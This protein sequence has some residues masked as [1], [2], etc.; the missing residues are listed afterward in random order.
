MT[1]ILQKTEHP[2]AAGPSSDPDA[3]RWWALPVLM[4]G[5][6]MIVLDFFV[7]NVAL[8]RIRS[9]LHAGPAALT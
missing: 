7:V 6:V 2:T 1:D 8:P 4:A 9:G 5:T 3:G